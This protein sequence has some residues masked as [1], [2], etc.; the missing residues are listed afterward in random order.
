LR[1]GFDLTI[2]NGL[3]KHG[4][5]SPPKSNCGRRQKKAWKDRRTMESLVDEAQLFG[6]SD[7]RAALRKLATKTKGNEW[8]VAA[9]ECQILSAMQ[10]EVEQVYTRCGQAVCHPRF[11]C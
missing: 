6:S 3:D 11:S 7:D 1:Q 4:S 10:M 2:V 8:P 9:G 5:V